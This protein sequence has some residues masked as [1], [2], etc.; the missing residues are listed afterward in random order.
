MDTNKNPFINT[1]EKLKPLE[2]FLKSDILKTN[3][4][5]LGYFEVVDILKLSQTSNKLY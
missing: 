3:P 5:L 1:D 2:S 4:K